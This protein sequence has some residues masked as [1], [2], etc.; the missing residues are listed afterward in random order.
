MAVGSR[1]PT[2]LSAVRPHPT[3][4][5]VH[6]HTPP[7]TTSPAVLASTWR[8]AGRQCPT[9]PLPP[10]LF[11]SSSVQIAV[12]LYRAVPR[13][14]VLAAPTLRHHSLP[15]THL[16]CTCFGNPALLPLPTP[17]LARK[18]I[19]PFPPLRGPRQLIAPLTQTSGE[20]LPARAVCRGCSRWFRCPGSQVPASRTLTGRPAAP[21]LGPCSHD[22]AARWRPR[23]P[24]LRS[25]GR[26]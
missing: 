4:Q 11:V 25:P 23:G 24:S 7:S 13:C 1:G 3:L 15:V 5:A 6:A 17:F 18:W 2:K 22:T 10:F 20:W 9:R 26:R 19:G 21:C 16:S 14:A 8:P 12:P